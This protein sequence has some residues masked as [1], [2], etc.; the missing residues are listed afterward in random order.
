M[1][2]DL[3]FADCIFAQDWPPSTDFKTAFPELFED[4][5]RAV[6]VPNYVRRD[7]TLNVASHFPTGT[8][9]PDLGKSVCFGINFLPEQG[10]QV[11]RCTTPWLRSRQQAAKAQ[12]DCT[13]IWQTHSIS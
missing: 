11:Q 2:I 5:S 7:G 13:W 3:I 4:F 1:I 6:P 12:L 9:S 10:V 8:I